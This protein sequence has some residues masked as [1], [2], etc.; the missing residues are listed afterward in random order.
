MYAY[1]VEFPSPVGTVWDVFLYAPRDKA[2]RPQ[3][4]GW[5]S[6]S[7]SNSCNKPGVFSRSPN[8]TKLCRL[9]LWIVSWILQDVNCFLLS[10]KIW[11]GIL[12]HYSF[13]FTPCHFW[14]LTF[15]SWG[16]SWWNREAASCFQTFARHL[17]AC[18][19]RRGSL[20]LGCSEVRNPWASRWAVT[21]CKPLNGRRCERIL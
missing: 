10:N 16:L 4:Q 11:Y 3:L 9:W 15:Q 2:H 1:F 7:R 20:A 18:L 19:F 17:S 13:F 6:R 12:Y 8:K 5:N 21:A 14:E